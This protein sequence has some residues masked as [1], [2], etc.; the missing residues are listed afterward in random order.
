[1][2]SNLLKDLVVKNVMIEESGRS[3]PF[4]VSCPLVGNFVVGLGKMREFLQRCFSRI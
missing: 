2:R 3:W 1:M 4:T